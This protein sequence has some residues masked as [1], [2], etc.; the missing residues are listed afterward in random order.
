MPGVQNEWDVRD[1]KKKK[2]TTLT[3]EFKIKRGLELGEFAR[4]VYA[5]FFKQMYRPG[6]KGRHVQSSEDDIFVGRDAT[7]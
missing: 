5:I 4:V 6:I 1:L 3:P 7:E 2:K